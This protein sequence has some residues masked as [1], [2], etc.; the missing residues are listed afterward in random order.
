[1]LARLYVRMRD[2]L[3]RLPPKNNLGDKAERDADR[4]RFRGLL[5]SGLVEKPRR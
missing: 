2:A 5:L 3:L 4:G 1:M